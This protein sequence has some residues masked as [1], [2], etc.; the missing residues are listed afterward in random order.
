METTE[1]RTVTTNPF[2]GMVVYRIEYKGSVAVA[3]RICFEQQESF[4]FAI[5]DFA[6]DILYLDRDRDGHVDE[7]IAP[8]HLKERSLTED[9]PPCPQKPERP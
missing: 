4:P 9:L 3:Y 6:K 8:A 5:A 2:S 1:S 7:M